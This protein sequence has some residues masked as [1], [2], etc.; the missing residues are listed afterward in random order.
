M[1]REIYA[2]K[3][4]DPDKSKFD[5]FKTTLKRSLPYKATKI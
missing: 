5:F 3:F 4:F 2:I 1:L